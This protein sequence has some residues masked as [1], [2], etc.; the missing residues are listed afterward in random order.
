MHSANWASSPLIDLSKDLTEK[1]IANNVKRL[2]I[3]SLKQSPHNNL[4]RLNARSS[5]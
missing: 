5:T 3:K 2:T 4:W 1:I